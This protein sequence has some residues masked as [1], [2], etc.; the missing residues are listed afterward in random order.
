MLQSRADSK[1]AL[2]AVILYVYTVNTIASILMKNRSTRPK[3]GFSTPKLLSV[4]S[5]RVTLILD[6]YL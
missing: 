1:D 4:S 2:Q 6:L 3:I 5:A